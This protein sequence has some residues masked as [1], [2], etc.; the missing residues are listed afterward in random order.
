MPYDPL[1]LDRSIDEWNVFVEKEF[2]DVGRSHRRALRE[3]L[4]PEPA[5]DDPLTGESRFW[6]FAERK[7]EIDGS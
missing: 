3:L 1:T 2:A 7:L 5:V 6:K 4:K